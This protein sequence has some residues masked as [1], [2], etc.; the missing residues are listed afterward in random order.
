M[1]QLHHVTAM[2][3]VVQRLF[4]QIRWI[5]SGQLWY[6]ATTNRKTKKYISQYPLHFLSL[7]TNISERNIYNKYIHLLYIR[8]TVEFEVYITV[9]IHGNRFSGSDIKFHPAFH[10]PTLYLYSVTCS[11]PSVYARLKRAY[12]RDTVLSACDIYLTRIKQKK[13]EREGGKKGIK[14]WKKEK[15]HLTGP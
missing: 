10:R 7:P 12:V 5:I 13:R 1:P 3:V 11:F 8:L 6:T 9:V 14:M 15:I 4:D 2:H